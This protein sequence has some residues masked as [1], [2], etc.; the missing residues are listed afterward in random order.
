[1]LAFALVLDGISLRRG[2]GQARAIAAAAGLGRGSYLRLTSDTTLK[3][4]ILEDI[5]ALTG[6]VIAAGGLGLWHVTGNPAWDGLA[7]MLIGLLLV[8][9]AVNLAVT[10]L[11]LLTG[12][13]ASEGLQSALRREVESLPGVE[14]V[15]VFVAVV[16]GPGH[17]LVAAK[18]HFRVDCS[19]ADIERVADEA[20]ER[21]RARFPGVR[22]V[23][24]DPTGS[25]GAE[26]PLLPRS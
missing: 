13:A 17:V 25:Q 7:S 6:L 8:V 24:L 23:F 15:H 11:S 18:V 1:M 16:L 9:V 2:L 4:V 5:A 20:E 26:A 12:R 3:A 22:Y 21:L 14:T 19:A 10:N